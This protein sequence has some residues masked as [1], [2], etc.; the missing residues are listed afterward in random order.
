[1]RPKFVLALMVVVVA[2]IGAVLFFKPHTEKPVATEAPPAPVQEAGN[3]V[4][5]PMP[6]PASV[7][8]PR[9]LT[10]D[11]QQATNAAEIDRLMEWSRN[12]DPESLANIETDLTNSQKDVREAAIEAAK[13]FGSTNAIPV[14]KADA[15]NSTD[16]DEQIEMLQAANFLSL[17]SLSLSPP[18]PEQIQATQQ[19]HAQMEANQQARKQQLQQSQQQGQG[20]APAPPQNGQN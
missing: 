3:A 13:Q 7:P 14:L 9:V 4:P 15:I 18:T 11:E 10:D 17:P 1:M 2:A 12:D 20:T 5:P 6:L 8:E 19:R 16:T